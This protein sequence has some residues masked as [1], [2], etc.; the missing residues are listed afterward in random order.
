MQALQIVNSEMLTFYRILHKIEKAVT[1]TATQ[2]AWI[3]SSLKFIFALPRA[4]MEGEGA[5]IKI[6]TSPS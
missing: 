2:K 6:R 3:M 4:T 5:I 1:T